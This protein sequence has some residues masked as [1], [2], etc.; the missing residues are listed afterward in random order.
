MERSSSWETHDGGF[1]GHAHGNRTQQR[2]PV[3]SCEELTELLPTHSKAPHVAWATIDQDQ[4][5]NTEGKL[6]FRY[7]LGLTLPCICCISRAPCSMGLGAMM[8]VWVAWHRLTILGG[9]A[10]WGGTGMALGKREE[11]NVQVYS[12]TKRHNLS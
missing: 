12:L 1:Y 3:G 4:Y 6:C 9:G 8:V 10:V 11:V 2:R 7:S 5:Q